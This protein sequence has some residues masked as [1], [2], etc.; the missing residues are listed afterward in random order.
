MG[1]ENANANATV[2]VLDRIKRGLAG[3]VTTW[4]HVR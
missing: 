2:D 4:L 1:T 3:Y